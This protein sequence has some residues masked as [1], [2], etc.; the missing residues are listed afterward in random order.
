M[1]RVSIQ[2]R[3][4]VGAVGALLLSPGVARAECKVAYTSAELVKDLTSTQLALRALDESTFS[5]AGGRLEA[6]VACVSN[7]VP[8]MVFASTYRYIGAHRY[9]QNDTE[10]ARRWFRAALELDPS[11]QWDAN[12]LELSNPIR[13]LFEEE[14]DRA[15][16]DPVPAS[17][18]VLA[19]PAGSTFALD[20]RPLSVAAASTDRPHVLQQIATSDKSI[21]G[22]WLIDGNAFPAQVLQSAVVTAP[23]PEEA[24]RAAKEAK[25][26]DRTKKPVETEKVASVE[27]SD[28]GAIV[29]DRVRPAEKTPLMI[30]GAIAIAGAGGLYAASFV[31]HDQFENATTT[32]ELFQTQTLTNALVVSSG[33]V[34][35]A[36]LG[37][38]Y[39]GMVLDGGAGVGVSGHF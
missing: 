8:V 34:L 2:S 12:E 21:R 31:T 26:A 7:P 35:L 14:R 39:W 6:G 13:A 10:G 20:G 30:I 24:A 18:G 15:H 11:Y 25:K 33:G 28:S 27:Y 3:L 36:G 38:G 23:T 1:S 22:T 4:V 16:S 17:G 37:V 19:Q 5:A 9:M 29:V 32:D